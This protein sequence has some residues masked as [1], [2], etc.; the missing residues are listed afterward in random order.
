MEVLPLFFYGFAAIWFLG[1]LVF[2]VW[3]RWFAIKM[4]WRAFKTWSKQTKENS[5]QA[6]KDTKKWCK[7]NAAGFGL[8][9][10]FL[11]PVIVTIICVCLG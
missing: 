7:D 11:I 1:G 9:A 10:P 8:L 6:A 4:K 5:I 3:L 2:F